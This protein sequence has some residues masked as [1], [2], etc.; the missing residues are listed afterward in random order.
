MGWSFIGHLSRVPTRSHWTFT[1][2]RSWLQLS[3]LSKTFI[4]LGI[5][6]TH[7][8][9]FPKIFLPYISYYIV[10]DF[11]FFILLLK[12][13]G[14]VSTVVQGNWCLLGCPGTQVPSPAQH[15]GL[16]I[17]CCHSCGVGCSLGSNLIPGRGNS[18]CH[19]PWGSQTLRWR[20][21]GGQLPFY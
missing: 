18:I 7:E 15:S 20:G 19:G 17:R 14:S 10:L 11:F 13:W 9:K 3:P 16:R 21:G 5:W 12:Q 2:H 4:Q 1:Q 6:S 8:V